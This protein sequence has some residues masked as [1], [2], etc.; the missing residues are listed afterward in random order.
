MCLSSLFDVPLKVYVSSFAI[1][2]GFEGI[3]VSFKGCFFVH[4]VCC[5][6]AAA[7]FNFTADHHS[8]DASLLRFCSDL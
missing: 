2:S 5:C 4:F 7:G 3:S 8:R 1:S 6:F